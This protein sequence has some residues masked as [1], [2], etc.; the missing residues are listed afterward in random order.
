MATEAASGLCEATRCPPS[1]PLLQG[2][3]SPEP[4]PPR[5][6]WSSSEAAL[7]SRVGSP[8]S[9]PEPA[10]QHPSLVLVTSGPPVGA[11][12]PAPRA[13]EG[14]SGPR[15]RLCV[16][17]LATQVRRGEAPPTLGLSPR[18]PAVQTA[19]EEWGDAAPASRPAW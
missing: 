13:A 7:H 17:L 15:A 5:T 1:L 6:T 4:P 2:S 8:P 19:G 10:G 9:S 11:A 3:P 12:P 18:V 16:N 14:L